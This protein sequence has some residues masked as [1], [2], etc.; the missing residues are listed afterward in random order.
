[1]VT[2]LHAFPEDELDLQ[3]AHLKYWH[4]TI[5][6][7][8]VYDEDEEHPIVC[9]CGGR[10]HDMSEEVCIVWHVERFENILLIIEDGDDAEA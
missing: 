5:K 10:R 3:A 2:V 7:E 6:S 9:W 8:H 1:M 4:G